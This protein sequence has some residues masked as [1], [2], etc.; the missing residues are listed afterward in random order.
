MY[1]ARHRSP[2]LAAGLA[3]AEKMV[4]EIRM[5]CARRVAEAETSRQS[6]EDE[7]AQLRRALRNAVDELQRSVTEVRPR[8]RQSPVANL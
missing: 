8:M 7:A 1:V 2:E 3:Q 6:A 5:D 4:E